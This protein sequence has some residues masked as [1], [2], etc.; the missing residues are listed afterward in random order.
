[1]INVKQC[2]SVARNV[3]SQ[4]HVCLQNELYDKTRYE[5]RRPLCPLKYSL[6][7]NLGEWIHLLPFVYAML[8]TKVNDF[9]KSLGVTATMPVADWALEIVNKL[10]APNSSCVNNTKPNAEWSQLVVV[11][12]RAMMSYNCFLSMLT[13]PFPI[14][15]G[16]NVNKEFNQFVF[17]LSPAIVTPSGAELYLPPGEDTGI[18]AWSDATLPLGVPSPNIDKVA[19]YLKDF[20]RRVNFQ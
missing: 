9:S 5:Y 8:E 19:K 1:M 17:Y 11:I 2:L 10:S 7:S 15:T 4:R 14:L 13:N 6:V 20:S 16:E 3:Y 18:L 12:K